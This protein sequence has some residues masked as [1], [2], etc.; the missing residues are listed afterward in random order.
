MEIEKNPDSF[1][2]YFEAKVFDFILNDLGAVGFIQLG[3]AA[4]SGAI[5][6]SLHNGNFRKK[7]GNFNK[8]SLKTANKA[9]N[10][11]MIAL[12]AY[13]IV[14]D[15]LL[16]D[17]KSEH[18]KKIRERIP[19]FERGLKKLEDEEQE[20]DENLGDSEFEERSMIQYQG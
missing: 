20:F 8:S 9:L 12:D 14:R 17:G 15:L 7:I 5:D 3:V 1:F 10:G 13:L 18:A 11:G 16:S 4:T 6:Y 19:Y 2:E